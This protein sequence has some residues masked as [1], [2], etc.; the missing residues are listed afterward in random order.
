MSSSLRLPRGFTFAGSY[1]TRRQVPKS[2]YG[3]ASLGHWREGGCRLL[4]RAF[5]LQMLLVLTCGPRG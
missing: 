4:L 3:T 1:H 5:T 2:I